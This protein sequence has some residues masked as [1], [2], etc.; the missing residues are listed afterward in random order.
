MN[1][2][3]PLFLEKIRVHIMR[4]DFSTQTCLFCP[5]EFLKYFDLFDSKVFEHIF[6]LRR[7]Q[8]VKFWESTRIE[9]GKPTQ[10]AGLDRV[11][12]FGENVSELLQEFLNKFGHVFVSELFDELKLVHFEFGIGEIMFQGNF[13]IV[14]S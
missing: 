5:I 11:I 6:P 7:T 10:N 1:E 2:V 3:V 14:H 12:V 13:V 4:N 8:K 9:D